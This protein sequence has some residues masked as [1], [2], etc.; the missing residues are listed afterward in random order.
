MFERTAPRVT[1]GEEGV[2]ARCAKRRRRVGGV[3][4]QA[5]AGEAVEVRCL[6]G[7]IEVVAGD[8]ADAEVVIKLVLP[9]K[10]R[11]LMLKSRLMMLCPAVYLNFPPILAKLILVL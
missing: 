11:S 10:P 4:A 7:A 8:V 9:T 1:A 6:P 3:E 2:A 5:L